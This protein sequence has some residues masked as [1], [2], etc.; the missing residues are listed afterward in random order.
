MGAAIASDDDEV[1]PPP[2]MPDD[3]LDV[4]QEVILQ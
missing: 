1:D 2:Q 4:D 3:E